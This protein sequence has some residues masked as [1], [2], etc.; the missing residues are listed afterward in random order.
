MPARA[1]LDLGYSPV[2]CGFT[3]GQRLA[4]DALQDLDKSK[5]AF[6]SAC[7]SV[8]VSRPRG[9]VNIVT[10]SVTAVCMRR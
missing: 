8:R 10:A 9:G 5:Y 4:S 2:I 1:Q 7:H 6:D 3:L